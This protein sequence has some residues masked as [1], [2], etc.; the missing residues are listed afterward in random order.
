MAAIQVCLETLLAH[1]EM[2]GQKR[3]EFLERCLK[4]NNRLKLLLADVSSLTRLED[5]GESITRENVD[6]AEIVADVCDEFAVEARNKGFE[7][8]DGIDYD[9][10]MEGNAFLLA[11]VFRN[12]IGNALAYSGGSR[13][14][15]RQSVDDAGLTVTVADNGTGVPEEHLPRLFERFYRVDKGRSRQLGGTGLGLSIVKNAVLWHGG[16][17]SVRNRKEGGLEIVIRFIKT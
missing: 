7:I 13:I 1:P 3:Q 6:L 2:D 17:V 10:P 8:I 9:S 11:S 15:L 12:L 5:G 4:A 14:E 16:T